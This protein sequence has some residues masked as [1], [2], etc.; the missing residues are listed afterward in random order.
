M[1]EPPE[2]VEDNITVTCTKDDVEL[3][4]PDWEVAPCGFS[5][6]VTAYFMGG[7]VYWTCPDCNTEYEG[8]EDDFGPDPD[9][10]YEAARE[11]R[12]EGAL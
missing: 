6:E 3:G 8:D 12:M 7:R 5:S 11:R 1:L 4:A 2:G 10:A 9:A